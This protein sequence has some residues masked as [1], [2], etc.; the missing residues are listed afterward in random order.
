MLVA[1][2]AAVFFLGARGIFGEGLWASCSCL[3]NC[4]WRRPAVLVLALLA[5]GIKEKE[6]GIGANELLSVRIVLA[7]VFLTKLLLALASGVVVLAIL[8]GPGLVLLLV[9]GVVL[10]PARVKKKGRKKM[11][12]MMMMM[13]SW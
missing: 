11:M 4:G 10:A 12:M 9:L 7:V 6:G 13:N 2:L 8:F 5:R 1:L 3:A